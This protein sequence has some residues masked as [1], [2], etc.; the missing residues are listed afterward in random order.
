MCFV[1]LKIMCLIYP[2]KV[3]Y[4]VFWSYSFFSTKSSQ[5]FPY[6]LAFCFHL[7]SSKYTHTQTHTSMC[8]HTNSH[9]NTHWLFC[10]GVWAIYQKSLFKDKWHSSSSSTET[11]IEYQPWVGFYTYIPF[12]VLK[13]SQ[14]LWVN[15]CLLFCAL[16]TMFLCSHSSPLAL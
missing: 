12:S 11:T 14:S 3:S 13:L 2:L 7:L 6:Y 4:A 10:P 5:I 8:M 9:I 15:M 1:F 16:K